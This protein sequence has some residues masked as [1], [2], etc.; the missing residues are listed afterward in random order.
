M[1]SYGWAC[2]WRAACWAR[3]KNADNAY[4]L[5]LTNLRPW[6][7]GDTGTA[8]NFFDMYRVSDTRAIFQ[9]DANLGTPAA[10]MEMLVYS[11]PGHIELLPAL[12]D[13]WAD[14]GSVKG[15]GVRGGF[16]VDMSWR[17]G[18]VREVTLHSV[19]GREAKVTA[20]GRSA[21]VTLKPGASVALTELVG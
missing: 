18:R 5:V 1:E 20:G 12:P 9:I 13:A 6:S 2:A 14:S 4:Q 11:R 8:M 15:A 17:A 10:V 7:G 3:L 21:T 16:T 19:G